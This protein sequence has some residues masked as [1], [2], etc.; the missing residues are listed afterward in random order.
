M[1]RGCG[2]FLGL[3]LSNSKTSSASPLVLNRKLMMDRRMEKEEAH[4]VMW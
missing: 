2:C 3:E 1:D 4:I